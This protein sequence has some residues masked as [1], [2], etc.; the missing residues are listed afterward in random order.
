MAIISSSYPQTVCTDDSKIY[1]ADCE[2]CTIRHLMLFA[3]LEME[4]LAHWLWPINHIVTPPKRSIYHKGQPPHS[5]FSIRRGFVKL[6]QLRYNGEE[7]I[8]RLIGPGQCIGLEA[9]LGESYQ[10]DAWA[11]TELDYCAIPVKT[12][13]QMEEDQ[14]VL[15]GELQKQW[16]KQLDQANK[17]LSELLHGTTKERLG[18]FLLMQ[19]ELQ[20]LSDSQVYLISNQDIAD[21]LATSKESVSRGISE[22]RKQGLIKR[23]ENRL[24]QL[25]LAGLE[26]LAEE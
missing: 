18:R 12:I 8:V 14:P 22:L 17:W 1:R 25:D 3:P 20:K 24:Y 23:V 5:I 4:R 2:H 13:Q 6:V 19:H 21:I 26:A 16:N 9:L 11:I 15:Y 10:Q 7:S